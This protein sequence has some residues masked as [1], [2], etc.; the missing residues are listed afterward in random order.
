MM[1]AVKSQSRRQQPE[2]RQPK[3]SKNKK[4]P[5]QVG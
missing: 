5:R 3:V 1:S 2:K 4:D